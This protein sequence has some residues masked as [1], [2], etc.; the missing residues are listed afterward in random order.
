MG[1][2]KDADNN[3]AAARVSTF[4]FRGEAFVVASYPLRVDGA[5]PLTAAERDVA[6]LVLEGRSNAQIAQARGTSVRTVANQV[7]AILRK[8]GA[9]SRFEL[10]ARLGRER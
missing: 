10:I 6:N 7:A 8:V 5:F 9:G 4:T 1:E 3:A 2:R